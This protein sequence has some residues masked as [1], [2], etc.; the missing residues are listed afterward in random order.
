MPHP[1]SLCDPPYNCAAPLTLSQ[2]THTVPGHSHCPRP[3]TLSQATHT[4]PGQH[5]LTAQQTPQAFPATHLA[6]TAAVPAA[7]P[8]CASLH[9][10]PPPCPDS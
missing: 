8:L 4:V 2:A 10:P 6:R 1:L 3:L 7:R 9:A 5:A